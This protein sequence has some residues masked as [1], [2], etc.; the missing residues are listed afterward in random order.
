[1]THA[2]DHKVEEA[3]ILGIPVSIT[4][5]SI[6]DKYYCQVANRDPGATIVRTVGSNTAE[7]RQL[8][9]AKA[10]ERLRGS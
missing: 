9:I 5:Y 8:A 7:A 2:T 1:M 4:T 3:E 6:G 10:E